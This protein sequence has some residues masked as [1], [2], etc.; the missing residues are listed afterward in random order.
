MAAS[1]YDSAL[2][3]DLFRD[4]DCAKL[5][6]DTAEIRAMLIVEGALAKA[7]GSLGLIPETA[8]KAIHRASLE[9]QIDPVA[10]AEETG[11]SAVPVPA[12]VSAFRTEIGAPDH[13]QYVHWGATSQDIIDTGLILRL[14][15]V[16]AIFEARL[17][18]ILS[19]LG[20]L[21]DTHADLPMAAR[22]YGQ[23]ASP[24]SFGAVVASW[25]R[26][27]LQL[28]VT[29]QP[30]KE[31]L[32]SVS[33][34]GAAGTL[35]AM[36]TD[37]AKVRAALAGELGL[38]DPGA[39][40]HSERGRITGFTS[41]MTQTATSLAKM[42]EDLIL[43]TQSGLQEVTLATAGG[44]STMPQKQNPVQP[45][46]LS[47]IGSQ[48][49]ALSSAMDTAAIH[50]QQ[51]D[52]A[53]WFIEWMTLPQMCLG[54][55]KA[56]AIA[57]DLAKG[58]TPRPDAM[59]AQIDDGLGLIYAEALSFDLAKSMP[60]PDAQAKIKALCKTAL[61]EN[62]PLA[63]L[64]AREWPDKDLSGFFDPASLLGTAPTEAR[65]FASAAKAR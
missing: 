40:W 15:Q 45:T 43:L 63:D 58:L 28:Q 23:I 25:G 36:G 27:L 34:S 33:L 49:I 18:A 41:W 47:A 8:A 52:G 53:A 32:L 61:A 22:T 59:R 64:A 5:F 30:V 65:A 6:S 4:D 13:A 7:Q 12:L 39:S 17:A 37:G 26:P 2:Y 10:L 38:A 1:V 29:L 62:T 55:A 56:L 9:A 14:R 21:A 35:S 19:A 24:T 11:R 3:R 48:M 57:E 42:G 54:L 46:L 16:I 20:T 51:R 44:S 31:A 50:R 60:R